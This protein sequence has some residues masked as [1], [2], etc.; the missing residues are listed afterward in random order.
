MV[1]APIRHRL[2]DEVLDSTTIHISLDYS[3]KGATRT[4]QWAVAPAHPSSLRIG[5]HQEQ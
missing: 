5:K 3:E 1:P 2:E 4:L